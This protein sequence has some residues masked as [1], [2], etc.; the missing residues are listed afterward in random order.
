VADKKS[1]ES[2]SDNDQLIRTIPGTDLGGHDTAG[3]DGKKRTERPGDIL[4]TPNPDA[5]TRRET[6]KH[7]KAEEERSQDI[8]EA[9]DK[10]NREEL[11]KLGGQTN[12]AG[13]PEN[14]AGAKVIKP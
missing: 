5:E 8:V 14:V 7:R 12:P 11:P 2:P 10:A 4:G 9:V 13:V 1:L 3:V 6:E